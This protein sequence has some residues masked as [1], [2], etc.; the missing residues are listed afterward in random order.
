MVHTDNNR[1][2][3]KI[4]DIANTLRADAVGDL[5]VVV[6][7]LAEPAHA[8]RDQLALAMHEKY[9]NDL[10]TGRAV[11]AVLPIGTNWQALDLQAA[12]FM[13]TPK[14]ALANL[15]PMFDHRVALPVGVH[16][17]A[18]IADSASI[19]KNA[20]VGA[21]VTIGEHTRIGENA[22]IH[23]HTSIG[24]SVVI[25]DCA[26]INSGVRV[27]DNAV[28]GDS[29]LAHLGAVIGA[30]GFSFDPSALL[31]QD[32]N[33]DSIPRVAS[34][35][36]VKIGDNVEIGANTTI[37]RGTI[38]DTEIGSG[39]KIDNLVQISHNVKVGCHC[40]I[41]GQSGIAGSTQVGNR[42]IIAGQA[43]IKDNITIGD[44]VIIL[45]AAKVVK[46]VPSGQIIM[47]FVPARKQEEFYVLYRAL[48]RLP[49]LARKVDDLG[50]RLQGFGKEKAK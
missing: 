25:G 17:S 42:V 9:H 14:Q 15:T 30:D 34:L 48:L 8:G 44:N 10:K 20:A 2:L 18:V 41:S 49:A 31:R 36:A 38:R 11:A 3:F 13:P 40:L 24:R 47:G 12:I 28:I 19:G 35:G 32:N 1:P 39:T 43:A 37:D 16:P 22:T 7:S 23:S 26:L 50:R 4:R 45:A 5:D 21:F 6:S 33:V 27:G 46:S 29:F